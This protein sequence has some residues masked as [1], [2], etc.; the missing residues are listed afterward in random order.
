MTRQTPEELPVDTHRDTDTPESG[1]D[2]APVD[3]LPRLATAATTA[4]SSRD[5]P[6]PVPRGQEELP[7]RLSD[8]T[9]KPRNDPHPDQDQQPRT[10]LGIGS[11][12]R[13]REPI[14]LATIDPHHRVRPS[15]LRRT[16][17]EAWLDGQ[18][19]G[20]SEAPL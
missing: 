17:L 13:A 2:S 7:L 6:G 8:S 1:T 4:N 12:H 10:A 14:D 15:A 16:D 19:A 18:M 5:A 20:S 9:E 11:L 3:H